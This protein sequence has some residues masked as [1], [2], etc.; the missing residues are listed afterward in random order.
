MGKPELQTSTSCAG[1]SLKI[2]SASNF[3]LRFCK[4]MVSDPPHPYIS[5]TAFSHR[6]QKVYTYPPP[7]KGR[8]FGALDQ[9]FTKP[10]KS[11]TVLAHTKCPREICFSIC[12]SSPPFV[13]WLPIH[14]RGF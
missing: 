7:P 13:L 14:P 11:A 9:K 3:G 6:F 10:R 5:E 1:R 4:N 8:N 2:V 12:L